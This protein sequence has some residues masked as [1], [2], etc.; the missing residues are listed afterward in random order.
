MGVISILHPIFQFSSQVY[1]KSTLSYTHLKLNVDTHR[2]ISLITQEERLHITFCVE[3]LTV[4]NFH[5]PVHVSLYLYQELW[6]HGGKNLPQPAVLGKNEA[7]HSNGCTVQVK[8][9]LCY[10]KPQ[11]CG[12]WFSFFFF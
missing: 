5:V 1:S 6:T 12:N 7:E 10:F 9:N 11:I 3:G 4:C 2:Q 8:N